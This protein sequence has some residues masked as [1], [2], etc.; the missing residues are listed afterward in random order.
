MKGRWVLMLCGCFLVLKNCIARLV[1]LVAGSK[2]CE[3][4]PHVL[5]PPGAALAT[6]IISTSVCLFPALS[7]RP[8]LTPLWLSSSTCMMLSLLAR[9]T[10]LPTRKV[11]L[12][13]QDTTYYNTEGTHE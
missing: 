6:C 3:A 1:V 11:A 12:L 10:A 2:N 9:D 13:H 7:L 5:L 8:L 4:L